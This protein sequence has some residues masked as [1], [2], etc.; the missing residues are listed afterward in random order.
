M[1]HGGFGEAVGAGDAG[2]CM[3]A[4]E[5]STNLPSE[6]VLDRPPGSSNLTWLVSALEKTPSTD[7]PE[8]KR[9]VSALA[10][11]M[12]TMAANKISSAPLILLRS[13]LPSVDLTGPLLHD[14]QRRGDLQINYHQELVLDLE[15]TRGNNSSQL[16]ADFFV[17]CFL[18]AVALVFQFQCERG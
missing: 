1:N 5:M 11:C 7:W 3:A 14:W 15:E 17:V 4:N 12:T 8:R 10:S 18:E 6:Y 2:A 13:L 9:N 16:F